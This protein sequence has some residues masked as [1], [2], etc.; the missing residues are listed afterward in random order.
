MCGGARG[1][2]SIAEGLVAEMV[3]PGELGLRWLEMKKCLC[4]ELEGYVH[5]W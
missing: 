2:A 5:K 3:L 1:A 4:S